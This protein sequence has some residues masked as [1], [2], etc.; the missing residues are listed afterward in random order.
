[1]QH[2]KLLKVSVTFTI[3]NP[4]TDDEGEILDR[5]N[6]GL[7]EVPAPFNSTCWQLGIYSHVEVSN[8]TTINEYTNDI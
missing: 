7:A 2:R 3:E 1:M 6:L 8:I 4:S 5:F